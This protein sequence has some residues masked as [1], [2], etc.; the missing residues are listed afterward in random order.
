LDSGPGS[1]RATVADANSGD[2]IQFSPSLLGETIR[3]TTGQI[4]VGVNLS[5]RGPGSAFLNI[6]GG[7]ASRI[8]DIGNSAQVTLSG[9]TLQRGLSSRGGAVLNEA[10]SSL[11]VRDA[12]FIGNHAVGDANGNSLGG[13][14]Y[15]SAGA[16]LNVIDTLFKGNQTDGS[17]QSFGGAIDNVGQLSISRAAFIANQAVG[18]TVDYFDAVQGSLGGA[19]ENEDG[20]SLSVKKT[21]FVGNRAQGT[22]NG[23]A[24]G[25]AVCNNEGF[26]FPFTGLG[27]TASLSACVFQDNTATG[28][29]TAID[30]GFG[31]AMEDL[32]GVTL[33]VV[34]CRFQ[35]NQANSGGGFFTSGGAMDDSPGATIT[36]SGSSFLNNF[37]VGT[38][39]MGADAEAGA[40]D[41]FDTMTITNS[42]FSGNKAVGGAGADG[43]IATGQGIGGAVFNDPGGAGVPNGSLTIT[44]CSF[45]HNLALG[46]AG[47]DTSASELAGN[48][49]GGA[50]SESFSPLTIRS[51]VFT[52]NRAVGGAGALGSASIGVGGAVDVR[53]QS[54]LSLSDSLIAGNVAQGGAG[55][56]GSTG[57]DGAGGGI[58]VRSD[59]TA[60][61]F[62]CV[63]AQNL[64]R[65]GAGGSGA[66]GGDG[67]GGGIGTGLHQFIFGEP[68]NSDIVMSH[69]TML[70]NVAQG[71][72]AGSGASAG[73]GL[74]GGLFV[75]GGTAEVDHTWV[76]ANQA[77]GGA[78]GEGIGGGVYIDASASVRLASSTL[79]TH[80]HASTSNDDIFGDYTLQ[81][82]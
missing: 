24:E 75:G 34:N 82:L 81:N 57:G 40:V 15:N 46:G 64:A 12:A 19:I 4:E 65:G 38:S 70:A 45:D 74:G 73:N 68:D 44:G 35:H 51:C 27:V 31:G 22:G 7:G 52:G 13:A 30:G 61:I 72:P 79:V 32:P 25:G 26:V 71:G 2:V 8:F 78:S 47:A 39:A 54:T 55:A 16:S 6:G 9:V 62:N 66:A 77:R 49:R 28:G 48:G 37:C 36:I 23:D 21:S 17:I 80:N 67:L 56:P 58:D 50:V 5:L 63:L 11:T 29:S 69:C 53:I 20:A 41:N 42:T 59:S 33:K 10:G 60:S 3:L 1:L 76:I 18:S 43:V 14:I